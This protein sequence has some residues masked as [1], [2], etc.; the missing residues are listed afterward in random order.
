MLYNT[1]TGLYNWLLLF[2]YW[3]NERIKGWNLR[4]NITTSIKEHNREQILG[5]HYGAIYL[6]TKEKKLKKNGPRKIGCLDNSL[7][8]LIEKE[9]SKELPRPNRW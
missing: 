6:D 7:Y 1:I 4:K 9:G 8:L 3:I 5:E 2:P